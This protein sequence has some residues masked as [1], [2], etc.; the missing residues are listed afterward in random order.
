MPLLGAFSSDYANARDRFRAATAERG[1]QC[2]AHPIHATG[3]A[4]GDLTIDVARVGSPDAD[5]LLILTSGLHGTE[6]LFGSAVQLAWLDGLPHVWEPPPGFAVLLIH[7]LNPFGFAKIRRANEDNIDLNRNFLEPDRFAVLKEQTAKS[8]GPLDPY[9]NP[10]KPPGPINW[11]P[12]LFPW[13]ALRFGLKT[14][15]HVLPAG[16][17]A[18]PKGIFYGGEQHAQSTRIIMNEMPRWLGSARSVLHLDFHT[19]LGQF[20]RYKLLASDAADSDR[21]RLAQRLFGSDR[22][23]ADHQTPGGYHNFGDIGEWLSQR[24]A[25]RVY[26]YLCAEFGTYGSTRVIGALRRENQA[27]F[28]GNSESKRCRNIKDNCLET[29]MPGS[30]KWRRS[31]LQL[32]NELVALSV[33]EWSE[34]ST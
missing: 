19:G 31:V 21:V 20:G 11:F 22:V 25:D 6:A 4:A 13:M 12:I 9:V 2:E 26:L 8:F 30:E 34:L 1:W 16:Q 18:F 28:W 17:Y 15:Q 33:K 24:F 29:F 32:S 23:E 14:L 3:F 5:R 7:A 10:P 27:H